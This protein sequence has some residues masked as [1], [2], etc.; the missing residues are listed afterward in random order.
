[1]DFQKAIEFHG[2]KCFGLAIGYRVSILALDILG[3]SRAKGEELVAIVE[4]KSCAIDAVQIITG[5]TLG[6]GNLLIRDYG[7]HVYTF[8]KRPSGE[9]VRIALKYEAFSTIKDKKARI[10]KVLND[11]AEDLF[12]IE[13]KK[14]E[15]PSE[16]RTYPSI[17]CSLCG[18][19]VMETKTVKVGNKILC[20]PC[21]KG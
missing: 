9:A 7:K 4:N 19:P 17:K 15:L 21:A 1:M 8:A 14:I 20:I 13:L 12:T 16:A 2:H 3:V 11:M 18:E 6:R 5:C 10:N